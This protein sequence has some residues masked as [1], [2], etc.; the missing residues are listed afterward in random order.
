VEHI[1]SNFRVEEYVKQVTD[2]KQ[3]VSRVMFDFAGLHGVL[4]QKILL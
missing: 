1:A 2:I 3:V 4:S